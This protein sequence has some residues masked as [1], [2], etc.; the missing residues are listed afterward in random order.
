MAR[1]H[2]SGARGRAALAPPAPAPSSLNPR[3]PALSAASSR[4]PRPRLALRS[5]Y[6]CHIDVLRPARAVRGGDLG[7]SRSRGTRTAPDGS[8]A[9]GKAPENRARSGPEL[10]EFVWVEPYPESQRMKHHPHFRA[11]LSSL[12]AERVA[13]GARS[14]T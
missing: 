2:R 13:Y 14:L 9:C 12:G 10:Q 5:L 1:D 7:V 6:G 3:T 11:L 8:T 4:T